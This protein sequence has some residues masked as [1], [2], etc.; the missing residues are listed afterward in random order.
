MWQKVAKFKGAEYFRKALYLAG[1]PLFIFLLSL[2]PHLHP[3]SISLSP[4]PSPFHFTHLFLLIKH[5]I[6][7]LYFLLPAVRFLGSLEA[8]LSCSTSPQ[9]SMVIGWREKEGEPLRV[10]AFHTEKGTNDLDHHSGM[11]LIG[12]HKSYQVTTSIL[13]SHW[14]Y[15][16]QALNIL[17]SDWLQPPQV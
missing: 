7:H 15:P 13:T 11:N 14:L 2:S 3:L 1:Y 4:H 5:L 12:T 10:T 16:M 6:L 8:L 17:L 9:S